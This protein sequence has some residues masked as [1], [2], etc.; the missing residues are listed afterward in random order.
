MIIVTLF[1]E[2][3][4]IQVPGGLA[5]KGHPQ[6]KGGNAVSNRIASQAFVGNPVI[7]IT[8][9]EEIAKIED[10]LV[11]PDTLKAAAAIT[12]KSTLLSRDIEAIPAEQ[13]EVWGQDAILAKQTDVIVKEEDLGGHEEWLSASNDIRGYQVVAENGTR[14]GTL[15]DLVLDH[16]G[17]ILGYE[18]AEVT[19]ESR[20]AVADWIDV[21][22]T[23]SLGPDVLI[24]KSEFV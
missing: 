21:K 5:L 8:N 15:G 7:G 6:S 9:G 20:V 3:R 1:R 19:I 2:G 13:V 12:S 22:A 11:D 18:M 17:Q 16:E 4:N 24:V 14:I 10:L 23:R